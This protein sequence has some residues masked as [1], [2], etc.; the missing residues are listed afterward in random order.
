MKNNIA[1]VPLLYKS[2][3]YGGTLQYYALE[4]SL[5]SMGF[6]TIILDVSSIDAPI[7]KY[8][9]K[10]FKKPT[11]YQR[12]CGRLNR[13]KWNKLQVDFSVR[14]FKFDKFRDKYI[15]SFEIN[16]DNIDDINKYIKIYISG[17]DQIW[18]PYYAKESNFLTQF[19]GKKIIYGASIGMKNLPQPIILKYSEKVKDMDSISVREN[20]ALKIACKIYNK[21]VCRVMDPVFLVSEKDW[22]S[23]CADKRE[24]KT[25]KYIFTYFM[26]ENSKQRKECKKMSQKLKLPTKNIPYPSQRFVA[27]EGFATEEFMDA[28]PLDFLNLIKESKIVITDSFHAVA[29]SIIFHKEFYV[30]DR[31]GGKGSMLSRLTTLLGYFGLEDRLIINTSGLASNVI[32]WKKVDSIKDKLI[33]ESTLFLRKSIED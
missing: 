1:V 4:K 13:Y 11:I 6:K 23:I 7:F 5:N 15:N 25:N 31:D 16:E 26:G 8:P 18:N 9:E 12:I 33:Q 17:S 3:N 14:N 10:F 19:K 29:F 20:D 32:D 30:L 22:N 27:G 2:Y 21:N 28:G 24:T